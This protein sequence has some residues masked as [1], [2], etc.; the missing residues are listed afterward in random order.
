MADLSVVALD[1]LGGDRIRYVI[2]AANWAPAAED[3]QG[4][5]PDLGGVG[6]VR[7]A[8]DQR[9]DVLLVGDGF[10]SEADFRAKLDTWVAAFFAVEV[11]ER[12][13][14]AFRIR[15]LFTRSTEPAT[16]DRGSYYGVGIDGGGDILRDPQWW[17]GDDDRAVGFRERLWDSIG[18]FDDMNLATY[19]AGMTESAVIH[20]TLAGLYS[21]LVVVMLVRRAVPDSSGGVSVSASPVGMTRRVN[22]TSQRPLGVNLALGENS[23]HEFGHAFAYLEDEY[24]S[25]RG[26]TAR[27][28]NPAVSSVFNLSNLTFDSR[29][30]RVPWTHLSPWGRNQR[31]GTEGSPPPVVG[32]LWRGGEHDLKVWHSEYQCLMNGKHLN[33]AYTYD[34][35][36]DPTANPPTDCPRFI[37][38]GSDLRW[39]D[40]PTYCLWC[41]EIVVIH[42]LEKTGQLAGPGDDPS[43][44]ERG[45]AWYQR[46]QHEIRDG[47]W[48]FFGVAEQLR[49]REEWYADPRLRAADLC[50]LMDADGNYLVLGHSPLYCVFSAEPSAPSQPPAMDDSE[51]LLVV[52]S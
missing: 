49:Q 38:G 37:D 28:E 50:Q 44:N 17:K 4:W 10:D 16:S 26:S 52:T 42:I 5:V 46:W 40:P 3:G 33:Y 22:R 21:N 15:A 51:E 35:V 45:V 32:W 14:G 43:I 47:Y 11:Y 23:L 24:I 6:P 41:Q 13:R 34:V 29:L 19:P 9:V 27:R 25:E 2:G 30:D 39:R 36:R 12:F 31:Q 1:P 8:E 7:L 18:A 48:E 20:N